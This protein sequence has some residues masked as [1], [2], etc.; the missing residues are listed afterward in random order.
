MWGKSKFYDI[1]FGYFW[2]TKHSLKQVKMP[3]LEEY[4]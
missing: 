2:V 3:L 4:E 1:I